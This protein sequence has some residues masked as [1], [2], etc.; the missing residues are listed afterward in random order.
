[1]TDDCPHVARSYD[2][3]GRPYCEQCDSSLVDHPDYPCLPP[4][5]GGRNA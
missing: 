2:E 5:G 1:M 3:R 4:L